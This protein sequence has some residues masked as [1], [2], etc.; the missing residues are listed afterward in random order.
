MLT[1][2]SHSFPQQLANLFIHLDETNKH[3]EGKAISGI[4]CSK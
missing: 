4:P 1:L 3:N 2:S